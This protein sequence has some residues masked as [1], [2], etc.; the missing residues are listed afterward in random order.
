MLHTKSIKFLESARAKDDTKETLNSL[1]FNGKEA[2]ATNGHRIHRVIADKELGAVI[3]YPEYQH[4]IDEADLAPTSKDESFMTAMIV[5]FLKAVI[6][7]NTASKMGTGVYIRFK[8]DEERGKFIELEYVGQGSS[9]YMRERF[10]YEHNLRKKICLSV[11]A[12]YFYEAIRYSEAFS[13]DINK[14]TF[15]STV[16][17]FRLIT[18][19]SFFLHEA[20]VMPLRQVGGDE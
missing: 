18:D 15:E 2:V 14:K 5:P 4:L 7:Y 16:M 8:K 1:V 13:L 19:H 10:T 17:R 6:A 12:K 20:Y 3:E 9:V 11:D